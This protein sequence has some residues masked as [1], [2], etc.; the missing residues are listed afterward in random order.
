METEK[1]WINIE[2]VMQINRFVYFVR[3]LTGYKEEYF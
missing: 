3:I 1:K 2:F